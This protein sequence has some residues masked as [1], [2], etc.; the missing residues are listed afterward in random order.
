MNVI[1]ASSIGQYVDYFGLPNPPDPLV[2]VVRSGRRMAHTEAYSI[3]FGFYGIFLKNNK[4]CVVN[5]GRTE[6]DYDEGSIVSFAP[7]QT[8][9]FRLGERR[10]AEFHR[11][12]FPPRLA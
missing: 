3:N 11:T 2:A 10:R 5:Y 6:Y 8:V 7:G 1:D 4:G 12:P 9:S